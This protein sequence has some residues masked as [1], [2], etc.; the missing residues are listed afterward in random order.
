M[1]TKKVL[2][3]VIVGF[4][5]YWLFRDPSGMA[6]STES[7]GSTL[8]NFIVDFFESAIDFVSALG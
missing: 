2:V 1:N 4:L 8:W 6:N 3:I 7:L 5:L